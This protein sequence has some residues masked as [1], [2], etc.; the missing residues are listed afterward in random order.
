MCATSIGYFETFCSM[1][2]HDP[3]VQSGLNN[4]I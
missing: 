1:A 3:N 2:S 4:F